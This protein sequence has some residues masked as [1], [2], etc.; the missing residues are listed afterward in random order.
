[1]R[2]HSKSRDV[3]IEEFSDALDLDLS[4]RGDIDISTS[5][6]PL[7]KIDVHTKNGNIDLAL[8]ENAAFDLRQTTNQGEA[9][10][11]YGPS[12]KLEIFG[13]SAS[14]KSVD[15]KGPTVVAT[16]DRGSISIKKSSAVPE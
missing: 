9:H 10:N 11:E 4:D 12:V 16:S 6:R 15:G 13:R 3:H 2:F 8:P 14:L 1:M 5:K 7:G